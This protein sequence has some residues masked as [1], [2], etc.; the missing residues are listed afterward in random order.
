MSNKKTSGIMERVRRKKLD[1]EPVSIMQ[2]PYDDVLLNDELKEVTQHY[3]CK[4]EYHVSQRKWVN[5]IKKVIIR[6]NRFFV[7][8]MAEHQTL[9][10]ASAARAFRETKRLLDEQNQVIKTLCR[11]VEQQDAYIRACQNEI[12]YL[13]AKAGNQIHIEKQKNSGNVKNYYIALI[14]PMP[15]Q[16]TGIANFESK[17]IPYLTKYFKIDIY[18]DGVDTGEVEK[19]AGVEIYPLG[20]FEDKADD[21]DAVIYEIGNTALYHKGIFECLERHPK[22]AIVELHDYVTMGLFIGAYAHDRN[23]LEQLATFAYG[24]EGKI[25]C[26][27]YFREGPTVEMFQKY[28]FSHIA[29]EM[30]EHTIVHNQWSSA[31]LG[32][33]RRSVIYH[34]AFPKLDID[35]RILKREK[36]ILLNRYNLQQQTVIGCF[37]WVNTNKR[38]D[39]L[40]QAFH[41]LK[42]AGYDRIKLMFWGE[43]NVDNLDALLSRLELED[44]VFVT[45]YLDRDEYEAAFELTDIVV[46]LRYPS[47]GE[48]SGTL[49]EAFV[50]G[51]PSIVSA[52]GQYMEF[53]DDVCW[54]LPV[55][56]NE[57]DNLAAYL[58][59]LIDDVQTRIELGEN[60]HRYA[61]S[62]LSP[63]RIA[64]E[65]YRTIDLVVN[66]RMD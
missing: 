1:M 64:E 62:V 26:D 50:H 24:E 6:L 52:V 53:P 47:M 49:A 30:A 36:E 59:Y 21:Y 39:V 22:G 55:D 20:M 31:M 54:K 11:Q 2:P 9:W 46:N 58:K 45:G 23:R 35:A 3:E 51:K 66:S 7:M 40:I 5:L 25:I 61:E 10:N 4:M 15:P 34:P 60:G 56:D 42:T 48:S 38:C 19:V 44:H 43:S 27:Q 12:N 29:T 16:K 13:L 14:T 17:L 57:T 41:Q 8:P 28:P 18:V 37:G 32:R 63:E 65:Y 33:G